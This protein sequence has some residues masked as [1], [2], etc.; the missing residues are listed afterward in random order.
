MVG[1][2]EVDIA[3]RKRDSSVY[4]Q[5]PSSASR[6]P[7]SINEEVSLQG[8][9]KSITDGSSSSDSAMPGLG[10][11]VDDADFDLP[12]HVSAACMVGRNICLHQVMNWRSHTA[13]AQ[14]IELTH[15]SAV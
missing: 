8:I 14:C 9:S 4:T 12:R 7:P 10:P 6:C 5:Q 3:V 13:A 15:T 2:G 11:A 1:L